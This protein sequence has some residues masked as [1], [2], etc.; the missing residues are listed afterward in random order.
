MDGCFRAI[1]PSDAF[2]LLHHTNAQQFAH[3]VHNTS[4]INVHVDVNVTSITT[5]CWSAQQDL[6]NKM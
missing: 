2:Q 3:H 5:S 4:R 1:K 6:K